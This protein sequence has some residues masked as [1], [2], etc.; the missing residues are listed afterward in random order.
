M[1]HFD[2]H[3]YRTEDEE[4]VWDFAYYSMR[5]Y[6]ILKEKVARFHADPEIQDILRTLAHLSS[7]PTDGIGT[8]AKYSDKTA[9]DLKT[10]SFDLHT[11]RRQGYRYE[12]LDPSPLE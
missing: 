5:S 12:R 10:H 6:L 4:G 11:L 7:T 9:A 3:A 8:T 2:G 1:R